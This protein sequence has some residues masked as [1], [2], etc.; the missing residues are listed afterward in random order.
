MANEREKKWN[1]L[2]ISKPY[3]WTFWTFRLSIITV[4]YHI[5]VHTRTHFNLKFWDII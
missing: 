3:I 5:F 4:C 2:E 1:L